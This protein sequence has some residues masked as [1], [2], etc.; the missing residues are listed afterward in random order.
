MEIISYSDLGPITIPL[1]MD[2]KILQDVDNNSKIRGK[3]ISFP[4]PSTFHIR[5]LLT[6]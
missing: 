6:E 4:F 2:M 1:L 5:F 3:R